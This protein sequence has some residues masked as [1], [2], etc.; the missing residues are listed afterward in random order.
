MSMSLLP[1]SASGR[2]LA[3]TSSIVTTELQI[4]D[5]SRFDDSANLELR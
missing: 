5:L 4:C 1:S 2:S 3:L